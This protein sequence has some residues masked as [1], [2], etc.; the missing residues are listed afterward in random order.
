MTAP[1][2]APDS[3]PASS[4]SCGALAVAERPLVT[5][6]AWCGLHLSGPR[7]TIAD[8]VPYEK[9]HGICGPCKARMEADAGLPCDDCGA[10]T[11]NESG[12]LTVSGS[13]WV[14]GRCADRRGRDATDG[15]ASDAE[16]TLCRSK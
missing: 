10:I 11:T 7:L 13:A 2:F 15:R 5:V 6:C 8:G 9:S 16:V 4:P 1:L 14:C 3:A 12:T